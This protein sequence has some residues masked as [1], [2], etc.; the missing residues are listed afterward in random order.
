MSE[1]TSGQLFYFLNKRGTQSQIINDHL[2]KKFTWSFFVKKW[3][4]CIGNW[5]FS[6]K[7][8]TYSQILASYWSFYM[9]IRY[10]RTFPGTYL[11]HITRS[12]CIII[13]LYTSDFKSIQ[14]R[15]FNNGSR[16]YKMFIF[17][18]NL[19]TFPFND[20]LKSK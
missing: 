12:A 13:R 1:N 7:L 16:C 6:Q 3:V 9:R 11:S 4:L 10:M 17:V 5:I 14:A 8:G 2:K 18:F 20:I 19:T 15:H